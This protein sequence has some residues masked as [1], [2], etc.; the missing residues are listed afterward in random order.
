MGRR[1]DGYDR[2]GARRY[3]GVGQAAIQAH[4]DKHGSEQVQP[5]SE[6]TSILQISS[7]D[8]LSIG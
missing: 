2:R 1:T 7:P 5:G 8:E 6:D 4:G 3:G